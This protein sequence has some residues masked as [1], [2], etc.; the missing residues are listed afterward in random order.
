MHETHTF[1]RRTAAAAILSCIIVALA[2]ILAWTLLVEH[3]SP[4]SKTISALAVGEGSILLDAGLWSFAAG[5]LTLG[6]GMFRWNKG[7]L[8]RGAAVAVMLLGPA[9]GVIAFFNEYA[10]QKNAGAD[11]HLKAV[12][13]L[14]FLVGLAALLVVPALKAFNPRIGRANLGFALAWIILAPLFFVIPGGW[15]G[16]YERALALMLLAWVMFLGALLIL[17]VRQE[18]VSKA[19]LKR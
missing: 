12:Y 18:A 2:D 1:I 4:I 14:G 9:I 13:A 7:G 6:V 19:S 17:W 16:A 10:G 15:N 5:C 11:I 8:W 3:Y